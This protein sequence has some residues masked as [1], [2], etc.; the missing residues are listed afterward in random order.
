MILDLFLLAA[1]GDSSERM[2]NIEQQIA[3]AADRGR[4]QNKPNYLTMLIIQLK[5][6]QLHIQASLYYISHT[7]LHTLLLLL[8]R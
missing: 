5:H 3:S 8:H 7:P 6:S 4:Q 2:K 1:D